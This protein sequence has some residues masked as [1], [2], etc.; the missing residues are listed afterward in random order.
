MN[1]IL[2][3]DLDGTL[4]DSCASVANCINHTL[5]NEKKS[6]IDSSLITPLVGIGMDN[7]LKKLN[8]KINMESY[9]KFFEKK[10][11]KEIILYEDSIKT[12]LRAKSL[13]YKIAIVTNRDQ[14]LAD[15]ISTTLH[16][17]KIIDGAFGVKDG[18]RPKPNIDLFQIVEKKLNGMI[19]C[20]IGDHLADIEAAQNFNIPIALINRNKNDIYKN[21]S[22]QSINL[23]SLLSLIDCNLNNSITT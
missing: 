22:L 15:L 5:E 4:A 23:E 8:I 6:P 17:D 2:T 1:K 16:L 7:I 14:K 18:V 19:I 9:N 13:G 21:I 10:F 11:I 12:L 3:F 20:H